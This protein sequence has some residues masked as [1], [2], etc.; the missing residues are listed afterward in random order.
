MPRVSTR[1]ALLALEQIGIKL[2]L[3][4]IRTLVERLGR[5]D[6]A[7][8]SIIVAGTNGKGSVTAM[9]E[10]GLRAAGYRTGRF[11]SPHL[12]DLEE[13]FAVNGSSIVADQLDDAAAHVLEVAR[14][15]PAPRTFF[16]A[17]TAIA[18][19]VFRGAAVDV[20]ILEVGLGGRLDATNVVDARNAV[21]TSIDF[22]HEQYLGHTLQAIAREKSGVIKP[23]AIVV[24]A[25]N[26]REVEDVVSDACRSVGASLVRAGEGVAADVQMDGGQAWLTLTTPVRAYRRLRVALAGRHQ[27]DNAMTA[28][29]LLETLAT[30]H[31]FNIGAEAIVTSVEDAVWP[32]RLETIRVSSIDVLLD[33]A[34]NPAGAR[35]LATHVLDTYHEP[36]PMVIGAMR[37]K[38]LDA[39]L[40]ALAPAASRFVFTAASTSRAAEPSELVHV[41]ASVAPDVPAY[42]EPAPLRA[43]EI[44][45]GFGRPVVVAG[46]L[47]LAGEVR[48]A[49]S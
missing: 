5:P 40:S 37:D 7:F 21:L 33:G 48:A 11:T 13:R 45:A 10:R 17:T 49:R 32:A 39:L 4:Q 16:A 35:A 12:V 22:D 42:V 31:T 24:L 19:E 20:A 8:P 43:V 46:S 44:A 9:I 6:Q 15:L 28:V 41:A 30:T 36:L 38:A 3:D 2:G 14:T 23:G 26:P 47:Y 27:A 25:K 18:L 1:A 34:H 29:R